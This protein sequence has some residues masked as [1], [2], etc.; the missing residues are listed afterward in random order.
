MADCDPNDPVLEALEA[1]E[2]VLPQFGMTHA[3]IMLYNSEDGTSNTF[4]SF[5][6]ARDLL[7]ATEIL[8]AA[9]AK[10]NEQA[11]KQIQ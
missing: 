10:M 2:K 11:R 9:A 4:G 6:G 3:V 1:V 7:R 5:T 8:G